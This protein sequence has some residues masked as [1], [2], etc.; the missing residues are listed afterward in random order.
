MKVL[1]FNF[2]IL[3]GWCKTHFN[4]CL[5]MFPRNGKITQSSVQNVGH[6]CWEAESIALITKRA[7]Y[8][9]WNPWLFRENRIPSSSKSPQRTLQTGSSLWCLIPGAVHT[10]QTPCALLPCGNPQAN[11]ASLMPLILPS[12]KAD[13]VQTAL[14]HTAADKYTTILDPHLWWHSDSIITLVTSNPA[15]QSR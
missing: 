4:S 7:A 13:V 5:N 8:F 12:G 3:L 9:L 10:A 11:E 2:E 6:F 1:Q 15:I 14:P